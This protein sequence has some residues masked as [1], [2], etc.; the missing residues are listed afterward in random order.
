MAL[1]VIGGTVVDLIFPGVSRLPAWPDHTEFTPANLTLLREPPIVT[2][3][4][5][6]ANAAYV[7]ARCG[8]EVVLHTQ[9]GRDELGGQAR[10]W[11]ENAGCRLVTRGRAQAT[12]VNVTAANRRLQRATLFYPGTP[13]PLPGR[14]RDCT[15]LLVCG[16]PLPAPEALARQLRLAQAGGARTAMDIGPILG[17]APTLAG[18]AEVW[19]HLDVLLANEHELDRLTR[20]PDLTRGLTRLRRRFAGDVVIKRGPEGVTWSPAGGG[21][22]LHLT[23]RRIEATNTVGAGDS[24]NGAWLAAWR[25]QGDMAKALRYANGVAASV[26]R[27]SR[28]VL[29]VRPGRS[30]KVPA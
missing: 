8:A 20:T 10:A 22:P 30:R 27:S 25:R 18:L 14:L 2:L 12:A 17:A 24:F 21:E 9:V 19:P 15:H 11:L 28:G 7:A 1:H 13:V 26:V 23:A 5:N 3:G 29:G 6:G 4:G 16:W